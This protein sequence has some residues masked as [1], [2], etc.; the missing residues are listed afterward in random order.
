MKK[1][2]LSVGLSL[3][4]AGTSWAQCS[5]KS[6]THGPLHWSKPATIVAPDRSWLI[7]VH[8]ILDAD[9][10]RTPVTIRKC[11][12]SKSSPLF[13]LRRSAALYWGA[14]SKHVL[15]VDQP[16]SGTNQLLLFS[17]P[18]ST[19]GTQEPPADALDK[20]VNEML[21]E[22]LGTNRHIQFYL[23]AFVSWKASNLLLAVGG[24][25]YAENAG[26]L[27]TYCYG[28][29]I[30]SDTLRVEQVLSAKELKTRTGHSCRVSP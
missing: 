26:P 21:V 1:Y 9:E 15:V 17:V 23:P 13:T 7:E 20:A 2:L 14:D 28:L 18:D 6:P 12:E 30:N 24:Q 29:R 10:N 4:L 3:L 16:V 22:R 25:T 11:G 19:A 27:D 5:G 8:P